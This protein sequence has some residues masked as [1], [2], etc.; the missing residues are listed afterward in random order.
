MEKHYLVENYNDN[1]E[2]VSQNKK[3][4]CCWTK[5]IYEILTNFSE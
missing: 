4:P 3:S 1:N 5:N 2:N